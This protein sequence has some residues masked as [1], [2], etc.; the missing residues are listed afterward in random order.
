MHKCSCIQ[1]YI[2]YITGMSYALCIYY[3]IKL[4]FLN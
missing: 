3:Y 2:E 1:L 4:D